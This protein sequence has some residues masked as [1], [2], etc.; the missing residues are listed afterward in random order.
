MF[1]WIKIIIV[2][3]EIIYIL[4]INFYK[5]FF[6]LF[7]EI[8]KIGWGFVFCIYVV[9]IGIKKLGIGIIYKN[10]LDLWCCV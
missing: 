7:V 8:L 4:L 5:D 2:R 10:F 9:C 6:F 1:V 3:M